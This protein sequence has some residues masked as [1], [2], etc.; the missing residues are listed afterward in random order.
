MTF[1]PWCYIILT[2]DDIKLPGGDRFSRDDRAIIIKLNGE[3]RV[4]STSAHNGG[5]RENLSH[6]FNYCEVYGTTNERCE[7]RAPT[8]DQHLSMLAEELDLNPRTTTGLSTAAKMKYLRVQTE[9]Y[10]DFS[11]TVMATGGIDA[12]GSRAGDPALWREK[13]GIPTPLKPGTINLIIFID[14]HLLEGTLTRALVTATE[15]KTAA[16][17]EVLAP[18]CY[19]R[20]L[21]TGSGTDGTIIVSNLESPVRLT[22]AGQHSKLGEYIGRVVKNTVKAALAAENGFSS[23]ACSS[24]LRRIRRFGIDEDSL[25]EFFRSKAQFCRQVEKGAEKLE[26]RIFQQRLEQINK[27]SRL[28]MRVSMYAHLLDLLYWRL[29]D[30]EQAAGMAEELLKGAAGQVI[31]LSEQ[32]GTDLSGQG[33]ATVDQCG[34]ELAGS[35]KSGC[36]LSG[37]TMAEIDEALP[38]RPAVSGRTNEE[39]AEEL[40]NYLGSFLVLRIANLKDGC[41][42]QDKNS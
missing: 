28:I 21:A 4:L 25:W 12:N 19:S 37:R 38:P 1:C 27:D 22:D 11:V 26:K 2:M 33:R 7:M 18:S 13:D 10:A 41:N 29:V 39:A 30:P 16:L 9:N 32:V 6:L 3:R 15:A 40:I 20:G 5:C 23:Y 24:V 31:A 34:A 36:D 14:A 35:D 17:Q 42:A 8:Y